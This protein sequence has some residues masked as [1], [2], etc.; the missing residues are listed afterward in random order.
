MGD[1]TTN[2]LRINLSENIFPTKN[3][4][5]RSRRRNGVG[6]YMRGSYHGVPSKVYKAGELGGIICKAP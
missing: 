5:G 1:L 4:C 2:P 6:G 3:N